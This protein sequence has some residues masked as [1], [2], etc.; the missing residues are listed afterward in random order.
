MRI[1]RIATIP[2][3]FVHIKDQLKF[4]S[5]NNVEV[6]LI[7]SEGDYFEV[8]TEETGLPYTCLSIKREIAPFSDLITL[9]KLIMLFRKKKFDIVHST[10]PKA[11]LLTSLAAFIARVPVRIHTFT[12]QR[13]ATLSGFKKQLLM[14]F[15]RLICRLNTY[16]YTDSPSQTRFLIEQDIVKEENISSI[17]KGCLGGINF[18]RFNV[19]QKS[20]YRN[21]VRNKLGIDENAKV[22]LFVGRVTKDKGIEELV[23]AFQKL[24]NENQSVSL[25]IVGSLEQELDPIKEEVYKEIQDNKDIHF[26]GFQKK[27]GPYFA[28]SDL[29]CLPSY[30]EGFGTVVLEAAAY[31]IPTIGT[32]IPGLIDA[33]DDENTGLLIEKQNVESLFQGLNKLVS[34]D[35]NLVAMGENAL[36]RARNDFNYIR[37]SEEVLSEYKRLFKNA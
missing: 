27:P 10:T 36:T 7:S 20:E 16:S 33:I 18:D 6:E 32:R 4:F 34:S 1:A 21:E 14:F 15:D 35:S 13:W 28:A 5:E 19:D 12:G 24:R 25:I 26:V 2:S 9:F 17:H 30:R 29:F 11:G 22:L 8:L 31:G 3:A 37:I 23:L